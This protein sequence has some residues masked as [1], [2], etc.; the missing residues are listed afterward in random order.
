[1]PGISTR[2]HQGLLKSLGIYHSRFLSLSVNWEWNHICSNTKVLK[3]S[4]KISKFILMESLFFPHL[5]S[6]NIRCS[7]VVTDFLPYP[8]F[9]KS[10]I[11]WQT[12]QSGFVKF[13]IWPMCRASE[14]FRTGVLRNAYKNFFLMRPCTIVVQR[15]QKCFRF[16]INLAS[17][18]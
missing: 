10:L 14:A 15:S 18:F 9:R 8:K 2:F 4:W 17:S 3:V 16:F 11:S 13:P 1:M 12:I 7:R 5:F 6:L